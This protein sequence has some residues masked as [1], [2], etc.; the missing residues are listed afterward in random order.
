[1]IFLVTLINQISV[2]TLTVFSVFWVLFRWL[3]LSRS[4]TSFS[5]KVT[6][7]VWAFH[8]EM[9]VN[10]FLVLS[11]FWILLH[12]IIELW[13]WPNPFT[14]QL[15]PSSG[16]WVSLNGLFFTQNRL[17]NDF[18]IDLNFPQIAQFSSYCIWLNAI[19][20]ITD[21]LN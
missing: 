19:K 6:N 15:V 17:I 12:I 13:Y 9:R 11:V 16:N 4:W 2:Q 14:I 8:L 10:F 3:V 18:F 1:M 20:R 21:V 5:W 7:L